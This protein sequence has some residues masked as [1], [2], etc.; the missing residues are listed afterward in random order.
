MSKEKAPALPFYVSDYISDLEV[1]AMDPME[2]YCYLRMIFFCWREIS[3]PD[4]L[5]TLSKLC[6]GTIPSENV[7]AKF[8]KKNGKLF[9]KK[10]HEIRRKKSKYIQTCA[11]GGRRSAH[12]RKNNKVVNPPTVDLNS[13]SSGLNDHLQVK[14]NISFSIS[15]SISNKPPISPNGGN[16]N[17]AMLRKFE[18]F[19]QAYPRHEAK[20]NAMKSFQKLNPNEQLM[21]VMIPWIERAK[22]SEQ[23]QDLSKVPHAATWLNQRR[24]EG[25]TPPM[26]Q[27]PTDTS[28]PYR[29]DDIT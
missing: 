10:L 3:I 17:G 23:W 20:Q 19:W 4:D 13:T 6:K 16:G 21:S 27:Q 5:D 12:K 14:P 26:Q 11:L 22:R 18:T 25:D 24:W 15:S 1:Q 2:E 28:K 9:H 8:V 29:P 7:L